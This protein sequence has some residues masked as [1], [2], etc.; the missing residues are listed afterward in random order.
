MTL[1]IVVLVVAAGVVTLAKSR[2]QASGPLAQ[3]ICLRVES[4]STMAKVSEQL[5]EQGA[6]TDT[7]LFRVG[8]E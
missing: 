7:R 4:G 2:Y 5:A 3:A 1:L 8:A 6:I